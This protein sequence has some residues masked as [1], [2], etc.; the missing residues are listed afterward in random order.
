LHYADFDDDFTTRVHHYLTYPTDQIFRYFTKIHK[1][2]FS[3]HHLAY[4]LLI[5]FR[6]ISGL[7]LEPAEV[8][9][10]LV[11]VTGTLDTH[12]TVCYASVV[13]WGPESLPGV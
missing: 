10:M 9:V 7:F 11:L 8:V 13:L 5:V 6:V 12:V 4:V 2:S 1:L 3:A